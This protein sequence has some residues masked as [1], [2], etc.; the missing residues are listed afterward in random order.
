MNLCT[1]VKARPNSKRFVAAFIIFVGFSTY[2]TSIPYHIIRDLDVRYI[3]VSPGMSR[4]EVI[5]VMQRNDYR[6]YQ[7]AAAWWDDE[8]LGPEA[9]TRVSTAI[10]YTIKTFYLPVTFEFTFDEYEKLVGRHRFD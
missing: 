2:W 8:R 7:G 5:S 9:D 3:S 1:K 10:R 4:N 6:N